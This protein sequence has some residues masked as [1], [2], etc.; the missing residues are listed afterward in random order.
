MR[1]PW[2]VSEAAAPPAAWQEK[3]FTNSLWNLSVC[4]P[5]RSPAQWER[6]RLNFASTPKRGITSSGTICCPGE[7]VSQIVLLVH[8]P[9][10]LIYCKAERYI[11]MRADTHTWSS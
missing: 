1:L 5:P 3:P 9:L 8:L 11:F 10:D 6:L 7:F 2:E 4:D